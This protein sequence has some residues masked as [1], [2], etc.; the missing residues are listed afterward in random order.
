MAKAKGKRP[1]SAAQKRAQADFKAYHADHGHGP[2]KG[3]SIKGYAGGR[4]AGAT[5]KR[6]SKPRAQ[7]SD[8]ASAGR[9]RGARKAAKTR[10]KLTWKVKNWVKKHPVATTALAGTAAGGTALVMIPEARQSAAG[11]LASVRARFS[12]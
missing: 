9:R 5:R 7:P 1:Q 2:P 6:S 3:V 4:G 11:G 10:S 12:R 8:A